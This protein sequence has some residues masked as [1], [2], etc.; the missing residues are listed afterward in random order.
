[1][2]SSP[3]S[4]VAPALFGDINRRRRAR[5]LRSFDPSGIYA[6]PRDE[7]APTLPLPRY[8]FA[9]SLEEAIMRAVY[10]SLYDYCISVGRADICL[11]SC[12]YLVWTS[13]SC[14]DVSMDRS[15]GLGS[16]LKCG[17]TPLSLSLSGECSGLQRM[18]DGFTGEEIW[19]GGLAGREEVRFWGEATPRVWWMRAFEVGDFE[20]R[21]D[22]A[23]V[24]FED[25][26]KCNNWR[27]GSTPFFS[28]N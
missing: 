6:R 23:I 26:K 17:W 8:S 28:G 16:S 7:I 12:L 20:G 19:S 25:S 27:G 10:R 24:Q 3:R 13:T 21:L 2:V 1:M 4:W 18:F 9:L 11:P 22:S 14:C 5:R 15:G